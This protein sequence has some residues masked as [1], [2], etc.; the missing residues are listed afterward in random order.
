V[1]SVPV[2][3]DTLDETWE[4]FRLDVTNPTLGVVEAWGGINDDD[5]TPSLNIG[6]AQIQEG[7]SGERSVF[8]NVA[9]SAAS[10]QSVSVYVATANGTAVA[11][12]DYQSMST[13]VTFAPGETRKAVSVSIVGDKRREKNETFSV[14]LSSPANASIGDG[15]GVVTISNDD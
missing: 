3:H 7:N 9:L 15:Y 14:K 5:P 12:G 6:D 1:V 13:T 2:L 11:P 10:G 8:L 4:G